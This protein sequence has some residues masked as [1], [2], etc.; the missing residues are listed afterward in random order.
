VCE[1]LSAHSCVYIREHAWLKR[2]RCIERYGDT[3]LRRWLSTVLTLQ[4]QGSIFSPQ[5]PCLKQT[6]KQ[7][8]KQVRWHDSY[9]FSEFWG[10]RWI[11]GAHWLA[12][13]CSLLNDLKASERLCFQK[14][15]K[16]MVPEK[17]HEVVLWLPHTSCPHAPTSAHICTLICTYKGMHIH[18][19]YIH[20]YAHMH[21][22]HTHIFTYI[23]S[24]TYT[25][26]IHTYT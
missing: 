11:Y 24:L 5:N 3:G 12:S 10:G 26:I 18:M 17:W 4:L 22:I 15:K 1:C 9:M 21:T 25:Y 23:L 2:E 6:N 16:L 19:I 13:Q 8:N 20:T 7:T 14:K